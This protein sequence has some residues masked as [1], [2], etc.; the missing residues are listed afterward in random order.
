MKL[1]PYTVL[2]R[3]HLLHDMI[4]IIIQFIEI[5]QPTCQHSLMA[6]LIYKHETLPV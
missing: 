4:N 6:I 1:S 3:G 5:L 2:S